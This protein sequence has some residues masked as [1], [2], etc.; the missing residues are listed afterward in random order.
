MPWPLLAGLLAGGGAAAGAGAAAGGAAAAGAGTAAAGAG[1][2]GAAAGGVGGAAGAA[3]GASGAGGLMS[4]MGGMMGGGGGGGGG[5]MQGLM[6]KIPMP[7]KTDMSGLFA[8]SDASEGPSV[9]PGVNP[10]AS[11]QR[12]NENPNRPWLRQQVMNGGKIK[13]QNGGMLDP[14]FF[15]YLSKVTGQGADNA[16]GAVAG[17]QVQPELKIP[18]NFMQQPEA[19]AAIDVTG[20]QG[21]AVENAPPSPTAEAMA[22]MPGAAPMPTI[23][24]QTVDPA[25]QTV[26]EVNQPGSAT[27]DTGKMTDPMSSVMG[28][29]SANKGQYETDERGITQ[30]PDSGEA[31][32]D[33][34]GKLKKGDVLGAA[35]GAMSHVVG[36]QSA[37]RRQKREEEQW[38][39]Q[40]EQ[41][42][43]HSSVYNDPNS[44]YY[45]AKDG[46][47][48][49]PS[50][51]K[52][53]N[54]LN[55]NYENGG[56]TRKYMGGGGIGGML[57]GIMPFQNGGGTGFDLEAG[58][59][60]DLYPNGQ[61][62]NPGD[63]KWMQAAG[64]QMGRVPINNDQWMMKAGQSMGSL[65]SMMQN[66]SGITPVQNLRVR[67]NQ[68][69][70]V[71]KWNNP[72][73]SKGKMVT[74]K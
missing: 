1:A 30:A 24:N 56:T 52:Q 21:V 16:A 73:G 26:G 9:Q 51:A 10:N 27:P 37:L 44:V 42:Q 11:A 59:Q 46:A 36:K 70:M 38:G 40:M 61:S 29:M 33:A 71:S 3:G 68:R 64:Q 28:L 49:N 22:P 54:N 32:G 69:K 48:I 62:M 18:E 6:S 25:N 72:D 4:K 55:S 50:L 20:N 43:K 17:Q 47:A 41:A 58:R 15:E 53:N 60:A 34:M 65:A 2:A 57:K 7:H 31:M 63:A 74:K 66:N 14:G 67:E 19:P 45:A 8:N 13:M 39:S 23:P 35:M 5:M 12:D